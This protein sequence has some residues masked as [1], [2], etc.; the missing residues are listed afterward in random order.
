MTKRIKVTL[1]YG[2]FQWDEWWDAE[3]WKQR[4]PNDPLPAGL[5]DAPD[6]P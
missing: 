1:I 4:H 3:K 2:P 6:A 5:R